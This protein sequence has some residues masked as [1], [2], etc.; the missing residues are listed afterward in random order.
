MRLVPILVA[1]LLAG[2]VWLLSSPPERRAVRAPWRSPRRSEAG[3]GRRDHDTEPARV[4]EL[5]DVADLLALTLSAGC[6]VLEGME[7]VGEHYPGVLGQQLRTV[8]AAARWGLADRDQWSAVP[9]AW[10]PIQGA[11][12]IASEAGVPPAVMLSAAAVDLRR[13]EAH[14]VEVA[15]SKLGATAVLPLGLAFL[16]AFVLTTVVPVVLGLA[17][18]VLGG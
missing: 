9:P 17:D 15:A 7:L 12:Q 11:L 2:A 6:G 1:A 14:R 5:A 18:G 4:A 10:A 16:P 8:T 13:A 3:V